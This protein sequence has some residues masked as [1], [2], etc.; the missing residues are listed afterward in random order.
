MTLIDVVVGTALILIVFMGLFGLLRASILVVQLTKSKAIATTIAES[1]MEYVRSLS[2]DNVGTV[3]GIPGG[4]I[5][6]YST[7][8]SNSIAYGVRTFIDYADDPADGIG[9][10]DSNGIITDYKRIKVTVTYTAGGQSRTVSIISNYSPIGMETTTGGGTLKIVVVNASGA[11]VP[12]ATVRIV[13]A[14]S[15]PSV[16]VT[17]F[18][19]STGIVYLPGAATSSQYQVYVS[20]TGYS[21]AQTYVRD[22]TNQNP[23]P[24]YLTVSKDQTTTSTFA[25]DVLASLTIHT[26]AP[27]ATTTFYD[28]FADAS[29]LSSQANTQVSGGALSL[30]NSGG[31][32][33]SGSAVSAAVAPTYLVSWMSASTT[34]STPAGTTA[35]L[36]VADSSGA[37]LPDSVLPGNSA[38]FTAPV[39]LSGVSTTTYPS[40]ALRADLSTNATSTTPLVQD[41]GLSYLRGPVPLANVPFTLTGAKTIGSTGAGAP[42]YKATVSASTDSTGIDPLSLEWDAYALTLSGY[43]AVDA[44]NAPPYTLAPGTSSDTSLYL[45]APTSNSLLVSVRDS[46]GAAVPGATVTLSRTGFSSTKASSSCGGAYFGGITASSAYTITVSKAGYTTDTNAGV[47]LSGHTFYADSL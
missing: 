28:P 20:N 23:T 41:W 16:D 15:S 43:D 36:H 30:A 31:Y 47:N 18:S 24:G 12:G 29:N 5:P 21:S 4:L 6:Q 14:S 35:V 32:A 11:A 1:Q 33:A 27:V 19:D 46:A 38:G 37:L 2:Y 3:G 13:N 45:T 26:Y 40:L 39:D 8:T 42:L 7:T 22:A 10:A 9:A 17:T 34:Q 44:C 25:I